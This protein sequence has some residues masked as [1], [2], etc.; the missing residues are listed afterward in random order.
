MTKS[1]T[2]RQLEVLR[3]IWDLTCD[4]GWPPTGRELCKRLGITSNNTLYESR[5]SARRSGHGG[6]GHIV[7]L[8]E[9]E[10]LEEKPQGGVCTRSLVLTKSGKEALSIGDPINVN[11]PS[12]IDGNGTIEGRDGLWRQVWWNDRG[13]A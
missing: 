10:L 4:L 6:A 9:H 1:P 2:A 8:R 7:Q 12:I 11:A 13:A 5:K 3:A